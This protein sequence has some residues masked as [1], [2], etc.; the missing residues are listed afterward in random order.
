MPTAYGPSAG[1]RPTAT[2]H[3][4]AAQRRQSHAARDCVWRI[5]RP[6]ISSARPDSTT[7]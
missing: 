5:V 3:S 6:T 2:S 1:F 4:E 7:R